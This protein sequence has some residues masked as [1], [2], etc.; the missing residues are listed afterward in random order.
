MTTDRIKKI[1]ESTAYPSSQSVQQALLQVWNE[2]E[3][4]KQIEI[5]SLTNE[6]ERLR[7][8]RE[9]KTNCDHKWINNSYDYYGFLMSKICDKCSKIE[10]V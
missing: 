3:Q 1:Q 6:V 7:K 5:D 8:E 2:C 4:Q 9:E 10:Y